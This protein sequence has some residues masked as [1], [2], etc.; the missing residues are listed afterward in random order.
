MARLFIDECCPNCGYHNPG[1]KTGKCPN[2]DES[3][4]VGPSTLYK[5]HPDD[6]KL[7]RKLDKEGGT[8]KALAKGI[9]WPSKKASGREIEVV[10]AAEDGTNVTIQV[11][12]VKIV[13]YDNNGHVKEMSRIKPGAHY[14]DPAQFHVSGLAI[15]KAYAIAAKTM[16]A[17]QRRSRRK[18]IIAPVRQG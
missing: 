18:M 10:A 5:I 8:M 16:E 15:K 17:N 6:I 4:I 9:D 2:C 3:V 12:G 1:Q 13:F 7:F 14:Y 11:Q